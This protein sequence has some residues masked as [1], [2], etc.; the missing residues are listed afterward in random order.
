MFLKH[1][2]DIRHTLAFRLT[3]WYAGMFSF[4]T[5]VAF[6]FFYLLVTSVIRDRIDQDLVNQ[7]GEFATL[8]RISGLE[9]VKRSAVL[10]ARAAGVKKIF[11]RLLYPNG[12]VFSSSNMD[13][14]R[15]IG[16]SR[17]AI[18]QLSQGRAYY[19]ETITIP[20]R[21]DKVR[22]LYG[23]L[24]SQLIL[25]LGQSM[26]SSMRFIEAF[27]RIFWVT[28][29]LLTLVATVV[30][31]F[32]ARQALS[33][34]TAVTRIA[35]NISGSE[36]TQRVPLKSKRDEIDQL[37]L[38]FNQM[39]DRIQTL[40][41]DI[42]EMSDNIAHDLKSPVTRIRGL[43]E[44]TMA[45]GQSMDEY[46]HLAASTIED[47]DRLLDMINTMLVI[48]KTE[49]GVDQ[50]Q[51]SAMDV[52]DVVRDACDLFQPMAEDK[53][54]TLDCQ[55]TQTVMIHADIRMIQ[56]MV[57]N[58]LDNAIKY[59]PNNGTIRI[60]VKPLPTDQVIISIADN[61]IGIA[62]EDLAHI[63]KRFYRCD[64]SRSQS[65]TGLGLSLAQ[66]I[67]KAH[68]GFITANS[69]PGKG[70]TFTI[71]LPILPSNTPTAPS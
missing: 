60:T 56:R 13:Y 53:Q 40:V 8:L 4:S 67:A 57:A 69:K 21:R 20:D 43:A 65:G 27:Q 23:I 28:M 61:G 38:T 54:V 16:V 63:F 1:L 34:V 37:A 7:K 49:A 68:G 44:V 41:S 42:H 50:P 36:L 51:R 58:L 70:S 25:Q 2:T 24:G 46:R 29:V 33:G 55:T 35:R 18:Q 64:R 19:I 39:L 48:S 66:T 30:G 12:Q 31:W 47:C 71:T 10:E 32:M 45:H 22:I 9:A 17:Q 26:E 3:L 5:C 6:I 15:N 52:A 11:F 59:T 62:P 14:W